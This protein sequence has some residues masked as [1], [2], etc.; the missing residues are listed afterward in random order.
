MENIIRGKVWVG[1]D[2]IMAYEIVIKWDM[3]KI[4]QEELGDQAMEG[5]DP[6]FMG[7]KGAFKNGG[8]SIVAAGANFGGGGKSIVHPIYALRGAGVKL[9]LAESFGR[10]NY[11][12]S[13]NNGMPALV[14]PGI[15]EFA[16]TGDELAV[17]IAGGTVANL[18]SGKSIPIAPIPEFIRNVVAEGGLIPYTKNRLNPK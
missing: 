14:C 2:N 7:K 15:L 6:V 10:F 18:S 17:D 4:D 13:I 5:V 12:N 11:K 3:D 16:Q 9:V 8:Y 1:R